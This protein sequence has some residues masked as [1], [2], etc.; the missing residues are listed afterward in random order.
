MIAATARRFGPPEVMRLETLPDPVPGPGQLL[1]RVQ[2]FAVTRGDTRI[3]GLEAPPGMALPMRLAFGPLRPRRIIPGREF[4]GLVQALGPGVTGWAPGD[5]VMGLTDGMT[6]GA[7]AE[8]LT[9]K[10]SGLIAR[11]PATLSPEQ[12]AG[13]FFGLL[14]AADFLIDQARLQPGEHLLINGATGAV[15]V[16]ALQLARHLGARI[17]AV[18]SA[19]NNALAQSLGADETADYARPLPPGPWDVILDIAGTLPWPVARP[20]LAPGG[21]LCL[22]TASLGALLGATLRPRRQTH[23]LCAGVVRETPQALARALA[24]HQAG[25]FTPQITTLPMTQITEA[26]RRAG[27]GHHPGSMVVIP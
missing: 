10:A 12:A 19:P 21:R 7:G 15:G 17:T 11:R 4:S 16:A 18:A 26:H 13:F 24:L 5:P 25:A 27:S 3:R 22:V 8:M 23:R 6:M 20:L 9:V 1:I 2:A 14:T